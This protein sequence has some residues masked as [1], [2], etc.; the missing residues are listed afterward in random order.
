MKGMGLRKIRSGVIEE[1][2]P[3]LLG[4]LI[5]RGGNSLSQLKEDSE[6]RIVVADNGRMWIDGDLDGILEVRRRLNSLTEESRL[7]PVGGGH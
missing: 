2:A 4:R 6:C 5:G 3:H 1:I 7:I